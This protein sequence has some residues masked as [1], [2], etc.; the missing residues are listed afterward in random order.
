MILDRAAVETRLGNCPPLE[1]VWIL[2]LLDRHE[3]ALEEG[4]QLLASSRDRFKPL[5]VLA[6]AYQRQYRWAEAAALHEQALRMASTRTREALVRHHIGRRLFDEARYRDAAAEFEWASDLYRNGG[7]ARLAE[8][9]RQ[10]AARS[11]E[12]HGRDGWSAPEG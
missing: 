5:L 6:H 2:S 1:R 11:R 8:A 7:R 3:E 12:V 4:H 10:A 9:S